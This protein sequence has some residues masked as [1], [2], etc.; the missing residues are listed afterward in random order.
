MKKDRR[1]GLFFCVA[2]DMAAYR[3]RSCL[4]LFK[5]QQPLIHFKGECTFFGKGPYS[6]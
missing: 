6:I 1:G 3:R 5:G 2:G 4:F